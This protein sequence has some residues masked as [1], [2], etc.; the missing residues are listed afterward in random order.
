MALTTLLVATSGEH[1]VLSVLGN[2]RRECI[3]PLH[4]EAVE[5]NQGKPECCE[6][7]RSAD[8]KERPKEDGQ[9][10]QGFGRGVR[11]REP[12]RDPHSAALAAY[13]AA[14]HT[15]DGTKCQLRMW[16]IR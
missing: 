15:G 7:A 3:V 12:S 11:S 13:E 1:R 6:A 16:M 14:W 8:R 4:V 9:E 2:G 5:Q 10:R